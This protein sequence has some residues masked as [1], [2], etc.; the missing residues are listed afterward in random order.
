MSPAVRIVHLAGQ[1]LGQAIVV[2]GRQMSQDVVRAVPMTPPAIG[3]VHHAVVPIPTRARQ[4]QGPRLA[5]QT[6]RQSQVRHGVADG[7][8]PELPRVAGGS[9]A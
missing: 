2:R 6:I 5:G 9:R 3:Q 8:L 1:P 4:G 7:P